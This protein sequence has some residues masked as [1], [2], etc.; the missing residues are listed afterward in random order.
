MSELITLLGHRG[1]G[2]PWPDHSLESYTW[3]INWGADFIEPDLY[4]TKDGVLVASHDN[5]PGGF[6]SITYAQA[7]AQNPALMTFDQII[8]LVKAKSIETGRDIGITLETKSTD[9]ATSEAV[10]KTLVEHGFTDPSRVVI[11][12]FGG[13][14]VDLHDTIMPEYGVDFPLAQLGS[15]ITNLTAIAAYAD[16][17]A[18]SVG[19][20]TAADVA[21]AHAAGLQVHA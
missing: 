8:E 21:A 18:P 12:S 2:D 5:I 10:I 13:N 19:S 3:G 14:L 4:L 20:F 9:Y 11:N 16:I 6:A 15:G 17:I 7:L 1:G